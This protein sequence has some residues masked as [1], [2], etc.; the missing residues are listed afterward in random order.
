L[1][2][3]EMTSAASISATIDSLIQQI[4]SVN[5]CQDHWK[6]V[7]SILTRLRRRV[8]ESDQSKD[9]GRSQNDIAQTLQTI[10]EIIIRCSENESHLS[11]IAYRDLES[12]L[13]RLQ[14]RL[15]QHEVDLTDNYQ[16]KVEILSKV[17][18]EQQILTQKLF[19]DAMKQR[20]AIIEQRTATDTK[21]QLCLLHQKHATTIESYLRCCTELHK[22]VPLSGVTGNIAT[23]V[24]HAFYNIS[25]ESQVQLE[26]NWQVCELPLTRSFIQFKP[27]KSTSFERNES[28]R[29][30]IGPE[31]NLIQ[32]SH[33]RREASKGLWQR[34]VS[35]PYMMSMVERDRYAEDE[36]VS[37]ETIIRTN[38]WIVI[39][40][41]PG[42]G[43][44]S[45]AR[46]LVR[47]L[48]QTSFLMVS[49]QLTMVLFVFQFSFEL[50]N[51]LKCLKKNHHSLYLITLENTNGW[52]KRSLITPLYL[53]M[54]YHVL[55]RITLNKAKL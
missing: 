34:L 7:A 49:I 27:D 35:A 18:Y 17:Y 16:A 54:I 32:G 42:S 4:N 20:L 41:D 45:F 9:S 40:G 39:L 30:L 24:A 12:L 43:K 48:A 13:F 2:E 5:V 55:F 14:L 23:K 6:L 26:R 50:E 22:S 37:E 44:T 10:G 31:S 11:K 1:E 19:E 29:L 51:S 8:N 38:R 25:L 47:H 33:G 21:E 46:W 53:L 15:A 36:D 52:V 3:T 28:R